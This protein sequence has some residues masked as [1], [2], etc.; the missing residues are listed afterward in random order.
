M[1]DDL[2][3]KAIA[4]LCLFEEVQGK[5]IIELQNLVSQFDTSISRLARIAGMQACN[6]QRK[7]IGDSMAYNEQ[8]F[9]NV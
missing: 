5:K 9:L 1:S 6:D 7:T 4:L 8:D 2:E 3:R